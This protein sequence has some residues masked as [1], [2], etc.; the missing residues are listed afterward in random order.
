MNFF[1]TFFFFYYQKLLINRCISHTW[2]TGED[3]WNSEVF[4]RHGKC[5][6]SWWHQERRHHIRCH[7][8]SLSNSY[9]KEGHGYTLAYVKLEITDV[10]SINDE[11][12]TYLGGK[13]H[14]KCGVH[15]FSF[16]ISMDKKNK[17]QCGKYEF[18][19]CPDLKCSQCIC[20]LCFNALDTNIC[21]FINI[22]ENEDNTNTD[23]IDNDTN[24]DIDSDDDLQEPYED[25]NFNDGE[26]L[27]HNNNDLSSDIDESNGYDED[28]NLEE[29]NFNQDLRN[30]ML[31]QRESDLLLERDDIDNYVTSS[32]DPDLPAID[33]EDDNLQEINGQIDYTNAGEYVL[34]V[35]EDNQNKGTYKDI[36]I[37]GHTILNQNGSLLTRKRHQIKG[38]RKQSFFLQKI[39]STSIGS[40]VP[41]IYPE[42]M[43]FPSI[44]WKTANDN[45]SLVGAIPSPLLSDTISKFGFASIPMHVR[46][47]LTSPLCTTSTNHNYTS[48]CYDKLTNLSANHEDT[49]L[50]LRR[51]LTVGDDKTGGLGLRGKGDST[52]LESFD[53]KAMVRNL[54]SAQKYHKATHFC[55]NT[56]NMKKHFG[57]KPIKNWL[58]SNEWKNHFD[59]YFELD[60]NERKEVDNAIIQSSSSLLLRIWQEVCQ[61]FINYLHKSPSSPFQSV[62]SIFARN[63]YQATAGNLSHI[64]LILEANFDEM[65]DAQ[66]NFVDDL[67]RCSI[68]DIVRPDEIGKLIE[69]GTFETIDDWKET[70]DDGK[71]F[72]G[73]ICD[74]R[75]LMKTENGGTK[76]RKLDYLNVTEDNTKHSFMSFNEELTEDCIE[77]LTKI[78]MIDEIDTNEHGCKKPYKSKL[79]FLHPKRHIPPTNPSDDINM[80][81]VEGYTFANCRSMQNIQLL[82]QTGGV[83]KYVCKYIG[84]IDEQNYI[85]VYTDKESNG[86]LVT[87]ATFLH[88]TKVATSKINEDKERKSK[89]DNAYPQGRCISHM[90]MLHHIFR[91]PEVTT[92]L[93]FV[94]I[95][96]TP[97][98]FR[99]GVESDSTVVNV[100]DS[101]QTGSVSND[102]RQDN[103]LPQWRQHT[104][105]EMRIYED[106]KVS[107]IS[108]DKISLFSLRPPEFRHTFNNPGQY[109]R[110]FS[111]CKKKVQGDTLRE[112]IVQSIDQSIWVDKLQ[113]QIRFRKNALPEII[114]YINS[115]EIENVNDIPDGLLD[116]A[117][118]FKKIN[119]ILQHPIELLNEEDTHFLQF[120]NEDL[121]DDDSSSDL[122]PVPVY[123][124]IK[125]TLGI[126][127]IHHILLSMGRYATELDLIMHPSLR[128]SLRYAKLIGPSNDPDDLV[129]YSNKLLYRYIEDQLQY[130]PNSKRVLT[131]WI[132]IAGNL[133]DSIIIRDEVSISDM[134]AVQLSSLFGNTEE[135]IKEYCQDLKSTFYEAIKIELND[136]IELCNIP[137]KEEIVTATK[138]QPLQW[139][140]IENMN[141]HQSQSDSSF[142]EQKL[143]IRIC[144]DAIDKYCDTADQT[145]ITKNVGIRGFP[146]SGKTWCSLYIAIYALSKGLLVLP[147][148]LL[149]KRA[150]QLGGIHWHKLFCI[151]CEDNMSIH[152][153]AELAIIQ[154]LRKPKNLHLVLCIDVLICD[155]IG[156]LPADFLATIDMI[157]RRLRDNNLY[158]GGVLII[159]TLDHMQIQAF[160]NRPLLTSTHI[161]TCFVMVALRNSVRAGNDLNFQRIQEIIRYDHKK[162]QEE[163]ELVDELID[164]CSRYLTFVDDWND[165]QIPPSAMRLYSKRVPAKEA[166]KDFSDRIKRHFSVNELR[167]RNSDDV[168][169]SRY[170][171]QEWYPA[172]DRVSSSL[173]KK[174]KEPRSILFFRGAVFVCT[175]NAINYSFSQAQMCLLFDLPEQIDLDNWRRIK[176]LVAP[177]GMKEIIF[178]DEKSKD[179][180]IAEGFKELSIG[181]APQWT[182]HFSNNIQGKRKQYGL[183]HNVSATIHCAMGD[184]LT[185]MATSIS[186]TDQNLNIWDKGQLVV[187]LSRT[188]YAKNSIFVG[189]KQETLAAFRHMMTLK[190]QWSEYIEDVL[191]LVTINSDNNIGNYVPRTL[192][193]T[194][195]PFRICDIPLPQCRTGYVY[196]LVSLRHQNFTYIGT[197]NCIR[198]RIQQH[199]C[200]NGAIETAPAYLRPFALFSYICGFGGHRRDLRYYIERKWKEH[201]D[202]LINNGVMDTRE[203]ARCADIV[204]N[205]VGDDQRF[206]VTTNE[207]SL[208]L[209]FNNHN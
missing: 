42:A 132:V 126:Q 149:A 18:Y 61:L 144:S 128:E 148:A 39:C 142:E 31:P 86:S 137:S 6:S 165:P 130:F 73:H 176:V 99:A 25:Q 20:K 55:T 164:L 1:L 134:P 106:L 124:Y 92:N 159:C 152:R 43:L 30:Q 188:K 174:L 13:S 109:F 93:K 28:D 67:S 60:V 194:S 81:P 133:F 146:G 195:Y 52:L 53:S 114:E 110:W 138:S 7:L 103:V 98:E 69:D 143:A 170:S 51:G 121:V 118:L 82:T 196:M 35:R 10:E 68:L 9:F 153:K 209:L 187:L 83:N 101:Q 89:K 177:A 94:T 180:Y 26:Y 102:I 185:Y 21:T 172:S 204:I 54:C 74:S 160:K 181:I 44:F 59:G 34:N 167:E 112:K 119:N 45:L 32:L 5:H 75:C 184:T 36:T 147:T 169:K 163:P 47:R 166:A 168:E 19:C 136:S 131:E 49:R 120:I 193:P 189:P 205:R 199:N 141:K 50:V 46:S 104:E 139:N 90:E 192:S 40:S 29:D 105:Y 162:V 37:S 158:L 175:F 140:A 8:N 178:D 145:T 91:Y 27:L 22:G 155:E 87:K 62:R 88:N 123:S 115:L 16:I 116:M 12:L 23:D 186:N 117:N 107:K 151:P 150:I 72:L 15:K 129:E 182:Q 127:F 203:W 64:H 56:C 171:Q 70:I 41:T 48:F 95:P 78:G 79:A 38:S 100:K 183:K 198:S 154:L 161:I 80:S 77:R 96:S 4:S 2:F 208:V 113:Q 65:T 190:S 197:T 17:C 202:Q 85:V 157:L 207:L 179:D 66:K 206:G 71:R 24:D 125:P 58:D 200:G 173:D 111:Y 63:E 84:K 11:Y 201:R 33:E 122:L 14:V 191:E 3:K 97:L 108:I 57:T 76:C 156:Q 135:S